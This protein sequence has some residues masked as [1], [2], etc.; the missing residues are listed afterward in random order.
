MINATGIGLAALLVTMAVSL[1]RGL[2]RGA[3]RPWI[4]APVTRERQPGAFRLLTIVHAA[5][6]G[7]LATLFGRSLA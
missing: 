5:V 6:L 1:H 3:F 2:E 4:G 7:V